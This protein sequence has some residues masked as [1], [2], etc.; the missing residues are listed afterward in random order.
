MQSFT[1]LQRLVMLGLVAF[2]PACGSSGS[3][4]SSADPCASLQS[5]LVDCGLLSSGD[6]SCS[7]TCAIECAQ[8]RECGDLSLIYCGDASSAPGYLEC[9]DSCA[10]FTCGDGEKILAEFACDGYED[11][12]DGSDEE[13]CPEENADF[14]CYQTP[15][16]G[17]GGISSGSTC[18]SAK[19][20]LVGCGFL[21]SND[22]W[23]DCNPPNTA[24]ET[25]FLSC[26]MS[27]SCSDLGVLICN[28]DGPPSSSFIDCI[29][30]CE[31]LPDNDPDDFQCANG[32]DSVPQDWVCD[33]YEDC[34]DNSDEEACAALVCL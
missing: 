8:N 29:E 10:N 9:Y 24:A 25:C 22:T 16:S 21:G 28:S 19:Q 18:S 6:Y 33:G 15:P 14:R 4:G 26:S 2:L 31:S 7:D 20:K 13:G 34:T 23:D 3:G 30:G 17:N 11:C 12:N 32:E 5:Q 1:V 27:A